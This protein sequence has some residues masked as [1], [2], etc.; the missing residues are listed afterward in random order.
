M[1]E[2]R[3]ANTKKQRKVRSALQVFLT[4]SLDY[5]REFLPEARTVHEEDY[6]VLMSRCSEAVR[7]RVLDL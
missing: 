4:V 1:E 5:N 3:K 6:L 2:F 7:R